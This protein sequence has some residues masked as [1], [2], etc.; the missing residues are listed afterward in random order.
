MSTA[1][2]ALPS[3]DH[4]AAVEPVVRR[5]RAARGRRPFSLVRGAGAARPPRPVAAVSASPSSPA[6]ERP[7]PTVSRGPAAEV[8]A[9][10]GTRGPAAA[11]AVLAAAATRPVDGALDQAF[12]T[13]PRTDVPRRRVAR[14]APAERGPRARG[15]R[16][17]AALY[18]RVAGVGPARGAHP[19]RRVEQ[20]Q[21]GFA[22]LAV[23]ALA[24]ALIV[25]AFLG[26]AHLRAGSFGER[27]EPAVPVVSESAG[28][29]ATELSGTVR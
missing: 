21:A 11:R 2:S 7:R 18:V 26:L 28:A 4:A 13:V 22:A 27:V 24:T 1:T 29:G 8:F 10:Y 3:Y 12:A 16:A 25:V 17:D 20:A 15:P 5:R 9:V 23:V 6:P 19:V 14:P